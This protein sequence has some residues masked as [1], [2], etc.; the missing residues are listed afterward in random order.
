VAAGLA[1]VF[2][3]AAM[4][5]PAPK[6]LVA[7]AARTTSCPGHPEKGGREGKGSEDKTGGDKPRPT[8]KKPIF[9]FDFAGAGFIPA[10]VFLF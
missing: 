1:K 4:R 8:K 7:D 2:G 6:P 9:A 3:A 10:R 5:G